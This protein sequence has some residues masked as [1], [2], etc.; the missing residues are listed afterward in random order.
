MLSAS[1]SSN[2]TKKIALDIRIFLPQIITELLSILVEDECQ[3]IVVLIS[4]KTHLLS[5]LT[6]HLGGPTWLLEVN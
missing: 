4:Q 2:A 1:N 3:Y 6:C 5:E